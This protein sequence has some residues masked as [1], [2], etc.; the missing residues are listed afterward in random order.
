MGCV[1]SIN[2]RSVVRI[3]SRFI[4]YFFLKIFF[5]FIRFSIKR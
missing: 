3:R 5:K 4:A 2:G 1:K